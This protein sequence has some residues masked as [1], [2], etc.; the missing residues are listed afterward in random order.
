[1][2]SSHLFH[3]AMVHEQF[4]RTGDVISGILPL[5]S[6]ILEKKK[7]EEFDPQSFCREV[8]STY[9]IDMHPYV[10][11]SFSHKLVESGVLTVEKLGGKAER[12]IV[13][14]VHPVPDRNLKKM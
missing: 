6:P 9:G 7:G 2:L 8:S 12:V 10:A 14:S 13:N 11:E 1:M 4:A 5:F 3:F